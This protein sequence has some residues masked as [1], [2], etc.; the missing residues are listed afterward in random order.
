MVRRGHCLLVRRHRAVYL[1]VVCLLLGPL[2][3]TRCGGIS[4][5]VSGSDVTTAGLWLSLATHVDH[6]QHDNDHD[7]SAIS[8][9]DQSPTVI[10]C[11]SRIHLSE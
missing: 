3:M 8:V 11:H 6:R 10:D 7:D 5:D 2:S 4:G 9:A 1:L